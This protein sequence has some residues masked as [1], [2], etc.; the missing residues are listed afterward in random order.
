M[1][2]TDKGVVQIG[3]CVSYF[4]FALGAAFAFGIAFV[5]AGWTGV[6]ILALV[7]ILWILTLRGSSKS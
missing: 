5:I 1:N 2:A 7:V 4:W 6:I 3:S